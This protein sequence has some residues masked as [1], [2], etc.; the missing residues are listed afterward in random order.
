VLQQAI[1]RNGQITL[2]GGS[3][4]AAQDLALVLRAGALPVPLKVAEVRNIG[5][6]LGQDSIDK[7]VLALGLA[8]GLVRWARALASRVL[9]L[10]AN[11]A[12]AGIIAE[13]LQSRGAVLW[14]AGLEQA[15]DVATQFAPEHLLILTAN[16]ASDASRVRNA[17]SVFVG[18]TSSVAFGDY[19]TGANHVLPTA[20]LAR[21]YS[22]LSTSDF[23]RWVTIQHVSREASRNLA[24]DTATLAMAERLPAHAAAA[25]QWS[26]A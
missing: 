7:G 25:L 26:G 18:E 13:A 8:L 9:E 19:M 4:Q 24:G 1:G 5:A 21:T 15:F 14:M 2:G 16:A 12:R 10:L 11:E 23:I 22:G 3:L 20:G 17:G 6:S